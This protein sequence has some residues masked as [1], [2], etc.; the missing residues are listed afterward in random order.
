MYYLLLMKLIHY[1][2]HKIQLKSNL[3]F[4]IILFCFYKFIK[5][6]HKIIFFLY[7]LTPGGK[8]YIKNNQKDAFETI[9]KS[10]FKKKWRNSFNKL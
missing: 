1:F 3:L 5:I 10:V 9:K 8:K 7:K 2:K 6:K 4:C